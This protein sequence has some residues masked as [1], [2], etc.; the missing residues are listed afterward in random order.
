MMERSCFRV[1]G[2]VV[3]REVEVDILCDTLKK[4]KT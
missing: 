2:A 4:F 1:V 3:A